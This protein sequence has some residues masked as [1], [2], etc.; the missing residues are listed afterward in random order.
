MVHYTIYYEEPY[1][2]KLNGVR[3]YK[4]VYRQKSEDKLL[5]TTASTFGKDCVVCIGDWSNKNTIKG[6]APSMG[7]GFK[8]LLPSIG[9]L[10]LKKI[11]ITFH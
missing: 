5:N 8:R 1:L 6:L 10:P 9:L 4:K 2:E 3:K 7:V 11:T